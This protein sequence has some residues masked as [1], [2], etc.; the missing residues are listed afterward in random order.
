HAKADMTDTID[1]LRK[2]IRADAALVFMA[3]RTVS[4]QVL[5]AVAV[6]QHLFQTGKAVD[7]DGVDDEE[8]EVIDIDDFYL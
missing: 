6:G 7:M 4:Y 3:G 8:R 1:L 2:K 5:D